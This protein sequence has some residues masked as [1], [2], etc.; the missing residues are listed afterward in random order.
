MLGNMELKKLAESWAVVILALIIFWPVGLILL[1]LKLRNNSKNK[2]KFSGVTKIIIGACSVFFG[3]IGAAT[4]IDEP[5]GEVG[6]T[7][8]MVSIFLAI[9]ITFIYFG[10]KNIKEGKI[11]EKISNLIN[12]QE[13]ESIEEIAKNLKITEEKAKEYI[14]K[15]ISL[16]ICKNEIEYKNNK[17]VYKNKVEEQVEKKKHERIVKCECCGGINHISDTEVKACEYCGMELTI[18]K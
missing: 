4:E 8:V 11:Y 13:V 10:A 7:I 17:I 1:Y 14:S 5:T 18:N 16:G 3:L 12:F 2:F 9:G 6:L 15:A